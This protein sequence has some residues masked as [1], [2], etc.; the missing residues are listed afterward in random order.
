[1]KDEAAIQKNTFPGRVRHL[2]GISITYTADGP[3]LETLVKALLRTA[4]LPGQ[5]E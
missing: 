5:K 3:K 2:P 1:M 4:P